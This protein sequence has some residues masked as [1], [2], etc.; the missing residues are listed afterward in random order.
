[1]K[2]VDGVRRAVGRTV[3][4]RT[5]VGRTV[6]GRTVVG[7]TA[8]LRERRRG[9]ALAAPGR[10]AVAAC[11]VFRNGESRLGYGGARPLAVM[12]TRGTF[13]GFR[14]SSASELAGAAAGRYETVRNHG[15]RACMWPMTSS[16]LPWVI[17]HMWRVI[18]LDS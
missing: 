8:L 2:R 18:Y 3:V 13:R 10:A 12:R 6:V 1:M 17:G 15:A 11:M 7:R 16:W 4:G 9:R 5:V 14:G